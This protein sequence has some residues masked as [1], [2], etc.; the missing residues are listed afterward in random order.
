MSLG[1]LSEDK[2]I[3][4]AV[5]YD[6]VTMTAFGPVMPCAMW[7]EAFVEWL[8]D[9]DPRTMDPKA[10]SAKWDDFAS[11]REECSGCGSAIAPKGATC[12]GCL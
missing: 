12:E 7:A 5:L 10:V 4:P 1:I 8:G 6:T 11:G 2:G 3:G 9:A